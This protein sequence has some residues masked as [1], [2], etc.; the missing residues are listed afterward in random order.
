MHNKKRVKSVLCDELTNDVHINSGRFALN[1]PSSFI[2]YP[3]LVSFQEGDLQFS[4]W[5]FSLSD[6]TS[7]FASIITVLILFYCVL[8]HSGMFFSNLFDGDPLLE[9]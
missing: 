6:L 8:H 4:F 1:L 7:L 9:L 3:T 5:V 2:F